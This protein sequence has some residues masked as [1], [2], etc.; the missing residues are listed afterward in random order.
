MWKKLALGLVALVVVAIGFV[1]L[2]PAPFS[3]ERSA[4]ISAPPDLLYD[5]IQSLRAMDDWS[6]F[7]R[8]DP[9]MTIRYEGPES[10]VGARS[11]WQSP[12]MGTGRL[13]IVS[14]RPEREVEM[15]LEML[16]PMAA[17]NRILFTLET[18]GEAT[19]VTWRM[20]GKNG[21]LGKAISLFA[22]M[23][24]MVGS[25]FERGLETLRA[26]SEAEAAQRGAA[27]S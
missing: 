9:T 21:F 17:T 2:Q 8:M 6:P 27:A 23:D 12:Q 1:A 19:R 22:D 10:G 20:E 24:S 14:V 15:R 18:S 5:R 26:A 16:E 4:T 7:G 13:E 3:V 25:Q 11:S